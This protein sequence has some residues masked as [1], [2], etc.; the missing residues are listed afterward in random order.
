MVPRFDIFRVAPDSSVLWLESAADYD[1]A[2]SRVKTLAASSPGEYL[3]RNQRTGQ[4]VSFKLTRG[5]IFQIGYEQAHLDARTIVLRR[6]GYEVF[7]ALDNAAAKLQLLS[8]QHVDLFIVGH[9]AAEQMRTEIVDWLKA[10]YPSV[11]I[12]ALQPSGAAQSPVQDAD[13]NVIVNGSDEWL[14]LVTSAVG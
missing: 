6:L 10:N 14:S 13:Y 1:A 11:K 2:Q 3:I 4:R 9:S 7:S 5:V 12:L 8:P